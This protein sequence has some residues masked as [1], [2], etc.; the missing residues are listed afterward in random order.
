MPVEVVK[1]WKGNSLNFYI[2]PQPGKKQVSTEAF[3]ANEVSVNILK[4]HLGEV[5]QRKKK[6]YTHAL[7][8]RV[9]YKQG[10]QDM[11]TTH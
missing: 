2:L 11:V 5:T 1:E 7:T 10:L 9:N 3:F 8:H 4:V 6:M